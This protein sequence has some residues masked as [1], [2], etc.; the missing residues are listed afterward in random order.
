MGPAFP[1]FT[2]RRVGEDKK[3]VFSA[4]PASGL[5]TALAA[6]AAAKS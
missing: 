1:H 4:D 2:V 3:Y 6:I 5:L